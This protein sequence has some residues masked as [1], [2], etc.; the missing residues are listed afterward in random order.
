MSMNVA[1]ELRDH[2]QTFEEHLRTLGEQS[3]DNEQLRSA[4]ISRDDRKYYLDLKENERGR[5]LRISMVGINNPRTQIAIPAQGITELKSTLTNLIEEFGNE[6]D[7]DSIESPPAIEPS[8]LP[9]SKYLRVGNKNFYF[10]TGSN[11]RGI[12]LR[13]SEVRPNFRTAI[14][15][16]E[17][18]W[19]RFRDNL[20]D[21]IVLMDHERH[22]PRSTRDISQLN[23]EEKSSMSQSDRD[24]T[25]K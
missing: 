2:L 11:N 25:K 8:E 5:F 21:F 20:T 6:D 24:D 7:R 18:T 14:T 16:P 19:S 1:S 4:V 17:K 23:T 15:L 10:D 13:I 12:F 9:E 3:M 22:N